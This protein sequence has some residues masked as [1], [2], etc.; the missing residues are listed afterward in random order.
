MA[1]ILEGYVDTRQLNMNLGDC[2]GPLG[3]AYRD[4]LALGMSR[5]R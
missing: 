1:F 3:D 5:P 2:P 4:L